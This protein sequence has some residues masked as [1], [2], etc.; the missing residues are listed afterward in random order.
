LPKKLV[1]ITQCAVG[2]TQKSVFFFS[3]LKLHKPTKVKLKPAKNGSFLPKRPNV[4]VISCKNLKTLTWKTN[5]N[6]LKT[7]YKSKKMTKNVRSICQV[8]IVK[9]HKVNLFF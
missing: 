9:N 3:D 1:K 2:K 8:I 5:P 4:F 7:D 6:L